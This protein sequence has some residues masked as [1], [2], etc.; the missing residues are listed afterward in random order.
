MDMAVNSQ[1]VADRQAIE[2]IVGSYPP[3]RRYTLAIMQDLQK[4]F[5][6]LPKEALKMTAVHVKTPLSAVFSMATF[7]KAFSLV[8]KGRVILKVCDGTACHIKGSNVM[9]NEIYKT[10]GIKPGETTPDGEFS[11]ETVNCLGACALAPVLVANEKVYA[12]IT[13]TALREVIN[14]YRGADQ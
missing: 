5:N 1:Q 9:I 10:L 14:K 2:R 13:P 7:Y 8:P 11:L 12:K 6:Y 3:E 4:H